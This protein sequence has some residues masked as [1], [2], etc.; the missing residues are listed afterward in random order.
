MGLFM[1]TKG[2]P[3]HYRLSPGNTNDCKTLI[4]SL[5]AIRQSYN[6]G[7]TIVVADKGLNTSTN[8]TNLLLNGDG[9]IYSQKVRGASEEFK[10]FATDQKGYVSISDDKKVKSRI[11]ERSISVKS[12]DGT[13]RKVKI[14]EKQVVCYSEKYAKKAR[15]ERLKIIEKAKGMV[16][17]K[18]K[19]TKADKYGAKRYIQQ[20][21]L[22]LETGEII[23]NKVVTLL[24]EDTVIE[25]EKYDGYYAVVTSELDK[26]DIEILDIYKG[27]WRIEENFRVTKTDLET[28]P[29]YLSRTEHINGHFLTCFVSLV[30][31]RL[32]QLRLES[33]F[34][35]SKIQDSLLRASCTHLD[36][37]IYVSDYTNDVINKIKDNMDI[38]LTL[39]YLNF[40]KIRKL[41]ADTKR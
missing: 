16:D 20:L 39:K 1:D 25:D 27:L 34:S 7:R 41:V 26:T 19:F 6:I 28:R 29:V 14:T 10:K 5:K 21:S 40:S 30:I 31:A 3:I 11:F 17:D 23:D 12:I 4:P 37:N 18:S 9:Y 8:I 13:T 36:S 22:D 2:V 35:I 33:E 38:D 24:N 15:H 32:L